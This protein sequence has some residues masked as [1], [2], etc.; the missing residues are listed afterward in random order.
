MTRSEFNKMRGIASPSPQGGEQADEALRAESHETG[1][2]LLRA[3]NAPSDAKKDSQAGAK[4]AGAG[5]S[6]LET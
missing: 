4:L 3:K 5:K 1:G 2:E 6:K